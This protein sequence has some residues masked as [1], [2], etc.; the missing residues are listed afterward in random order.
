MHTEQFQVGD[1][2][3][4]YSCIHSQS[5]LEIETQ[6]FYPALVWNSE[7]GVAVEQI[8]AVIRKLYTSGCR[9]VVAG[10]VNCERW[11]DI[12]DEE[13]VSQF[14]SDADQDENFVMTSW[15]EGESP[16]D[17][18]FFFVNNTNFENHDFKRFVVLQFGED[19]M[20]ESQLKQGIRKWAGRPAG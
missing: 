11:H 13:F 18:T 15:H 20:V 5:D 17:V 14:V 16:E 9:Y 1:R 8:T 12:A 19:S 7:P 3:F 4:F 10:G 2:Q 6:S